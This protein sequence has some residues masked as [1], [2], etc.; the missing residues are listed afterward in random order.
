[1]SKLLDT[2]SVKKVAASPYLWLGLGIGVSVGFVLA[3]GL[4]F[5]RE[6]GARFM[7][8]LL[9][10]VIAV[11][12]AISLYYLKENES[13]ER[14]RSHIIKLLETGY[15]QSTNGL[16]YVDL[17]DRL[18]VNDTISMLALHIRRVK[19]FMERFEFEDHRVSECAVAF[20][21]HF[22]DRLEELGNDENVSDERDRVIRSLLTFQARTFLTALG[23]M[24]GESRF[25]PID[26]EIEQNGE[27]DTSE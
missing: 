18:Q 12:G 19:K 4:A 21:I 2:N 22:A 23:V 7:G 1:M 13:V 17:G 26:I 20:D 15:K 6:D 16:Q 14:N 3:S 24:K 5:S 10:S 11:G 8:A 25:G 27:V 9:G